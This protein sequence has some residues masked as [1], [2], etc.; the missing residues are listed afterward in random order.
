MDCWDANGTGML[1]S[2]YEILFC[3]RDMLGLYEKQLLGL[4]GETPT[5]IKKTKDDIEKRICEI[6]NKLESGL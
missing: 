6:E 2:E 3:V 5:R 4:Y 1:S